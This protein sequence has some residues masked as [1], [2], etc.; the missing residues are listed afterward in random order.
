MPK[1]RILLKWLLPIGAAF[2]ASCMN[3]GTE[4]PNGITGNLY[5]PNG[6]PAVDAQVTLY[7]VNY[8]PGIDSTPLNTVQT[9]AQ[10]RFQFSKVTSGQYNVLSRVGVTTS[11]T[12]ADKRS[13]NSD[14]SLYSFTDSISLSEGQEIP[15]DTLR[16]AA[17]LTGT[18][19]LQPQDDPR[20]ALVRLLGTNYYT[21]VDSNGTFMLS[22]LAQGVYQL[23][24]IVT[25][26]SYTP[27]FQTILL[28]AGQNDTLPQPL[29]PFYS[30]IP[31]VTGLRATPQTNGSVA[32]EWHKSAYNK[33]LAYQVYRAPAGSVDA[34]IL[35]ATGTDT[36]YTD[37][38]YSPSYGIPPQGVQ[39][40]FTDTVPHSFSYRVVIVNQSD[41]TGPFFG[42][43]T[44][45]ALPPALQL[46]SGRW[47]LALAQAPFNATGNTALVFNNQLW[48]IG[49]QGAVWSSPD[50]VSWQNRA[51]VNLGY[52]YDNLEA[53]TFHDTLWV[54][55]VHLISNTY[56]NFLWKSGDG[57]NWIRVSDRFMPSYNFQEF[58]NFGDSSRTEFAFTE[59]Q[60]KLWIV[61]GMGRAGYDVVSG[62]V[63]SSADGANWDSTHVS[64][65]GTYACCF[66]Q[67][68]SAASSAAVLNENMWIT[69]GVIGEADGPYFNLSVWNSSNATSWTAAVS[70]PPFLPRSGSTLTSYAGSLWVI[71]GGCRHSNRLQQR[72]SG[73]FIANR[74][75]Y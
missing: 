49:N 66:A 16:D 68:L 60:N 4:I 28:R 30:N 58:S 21:N 10:G 6:K 32:L 7:P 71:G 53:A 69:G 23:Q 70:N 27:L 14:D 36:T 52:S 22:H 38:V 2:A 64:N 19:Q 11:A 46:A 24:V 50:G 57:V 3:S 18:I 15:P 17:S 59:F 34:G 8:V 75:G 51:S 47:H 62:K 39:Y 9:D 13:I 61:G 1:L 5:L 25:L 67:S 35:I 41:E 48:I 20:A 65:S 42:A 45:T 56:F 33:V 44:A 74:C 26:P 55:G 31:V 12:V 72:P 29:I 63:F 40:P 43:A 54:S 37:T 73:K